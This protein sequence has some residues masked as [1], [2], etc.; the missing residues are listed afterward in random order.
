MTALQTTL[1]EDLLEVGQRLTREHPDVPAGSVLRCYARAVR[2]ARM[3]GCPAE[4]LPATAEASTRWMLAQR[5]G[6][7]A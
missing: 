3:W 4:H 6:D 5:R 2:N 1:G 7:G